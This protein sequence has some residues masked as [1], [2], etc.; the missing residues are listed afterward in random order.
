MNDLKSKRPTVWINEIP[1]HEMNVDDEL[2]LCCEGAWAR[3]LEDSL[4]KT[5]YQWQHMPG[6]M[7]VNPYLECPKIYHSTDFG[8]VEKVDIAYTDAEND[9]Y[10][11]KFEKQIHGP[12]DISKIQMPKI[13]Y[14]KDITKITYDLMNDVFSGIIPVR[15]VGQSHIWYTPWD[16]LIRWWGIEDA[17]MDLIVRPEMVHAA[18]E[19]M[20]SAWMSELDQFEKLNLLELDNN[21]TRVGSGG[22]GYVSDLP[23]ADFN[24]ENVLPKNMW[25]C[26]NAQIFSSV[27]PKM[28]WEFA[29]EHDL[30]WLER[31]GLV[32]YGCCEPLEQKMDI[33]R[34]VPN[35]GKVSVSPWCN[36]DKVVDAIGTDYVMSRK[37]NPAIFAG[38]YDENEAE[39]QL[40]DF[41]DRAQGCHVEIIMKDISTVNYSP[42]NL[43]KWEKMSMRVVNDYSL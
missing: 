23:G 15:L 14:H 8:I 2:T 12:E 36:T 9:I 26:S 32:Y 43:W 17:M 40:R 25:G 4:R 20:V 35:L 11:R 39:K 34:R 41:L 29:L 10:S 28:H 5:I 27:S 16:Y 30:K 1:W 42:Q 24:S 38:R 3:G 6:D 37:A 22:Y 7:V 13:T 33:L 31:W 21:N 19:Q 18:Y